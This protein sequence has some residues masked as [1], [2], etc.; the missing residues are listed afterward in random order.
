MTNHSRPG[1]RALTP[2]TP[3]A[4]GR[5]SRAPA[6]PIAPVP[7]RRNSDSPPGSDGHLAKKNRRWR[8]RKTGRKSV[9]VNYSDRE[10]ETGR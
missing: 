10:R 8:K 4:A 3:P 1:R 2:C 6:F 5:G 7:A 9:E